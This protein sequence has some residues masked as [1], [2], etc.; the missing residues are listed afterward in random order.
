[1]PDNIVPAQAALDGASGFDSTFN[2]AYH[3]KFDQQSSVVSDIAGGAVAAVVDFGASVWNSLPGTDYVGT[4]QMLSRVSDNAM[5]VYEE[6][7]DAVHATSFIAG[8]FAPTG[9]ALKGMS[10]LRAGAKGASW[11]SNA[12]KAADLAK[13]DKLFIEGAAA[14]S[15]YRAA[16]TAFYAR[17]LVNQVTDAAAMEFA[18][19]GS[20]HAHPLMEDYMADPVKNFGISLAFGGVIGGT[21]GHIA[22]RFQVGKLEHAAESKIVNELT[23]DLTVVHPAEQFAEQIASHQANIGTLEKIIQGKAALGK[24][25]ANDLA[26]GTANK[27]L[28]ST[29]AKQNEAFEAMVSP[30]I[31][32]ATKADPSIR[33]AM[34]EMV[35][36][37]G[38]TGAN[39]VGYLTQHVDGA[40][41]ILKM[42]AGDSFLSG[43]VFGKKVSNMTD[44]ITGIKTVKES[45]ID[46]AYSPEFGRFYA[47]RDVKHYGRARDLNISVDA[48]AKGMGDFHVPN[49][50]IAEETL[51]KNSAA[52]DGH[53]I[54]ALKRVDEMSAKQVKEIVMST[55]DLPLRNAVLA[56]IAKEPDEF[57]GHKWKVTDNRPNFEAFNQQ[58]IVSQAANG[59]KPSHLADNMLFTTPEAM[60]RY[61]LN[62]RLAR[63]TPERGLI[64]SWI[65]GDKEPLAAAME[66][67]RLGKETAGDAVGTAIY[68]SPESV[69]LR[70]K[71]AANADKDGYVYLYRGMTKGKAVGH[72]RLDSYTTDPAKAL[73]FT[74][75]N[76]SNVRLYKVNVDDIIGGVRD[77]PG[78]QGGVWKNEIIVRAGTLETHA[79]PATLPMT[80]ATQVK[81]LAAKTS[82]GVIETD[83]MQLSQQLID[84]KDSTISSM[85]AQGI[86]LETIAIRTNTPLETVNIFSHMPEGSS[87]VDIQNA[88]GHMEY[89]SASR[90]GQYLDPTK[91]TLRVSSDI[92][93]QNFSQLTANLD[94][95]AKFNMHNEITSAILAGSGSVFAKDLGSYYFSKERQPLL[96]MIRAKLGEFVNGGSGNRFL[97]SSDHFSRNMGDVGMIVNTMGKDIVKKTNNAIDSVLEPLNLHYSRIMKDS[98]ALAEY[99]TAVNVNAGIKGWREFKDGQFWIRR[100][101][102]N[103]DGSV[104]TSLEAVTFQGKE[105]KV[106]SES[107]HDIFTQHQVAGRELYEMK[108]TIN[109]ILGKPKMSD[110]GLWLPSFNPK[111]KFIAYVHNKVDDTTRLLWGNTPEELVS[112]K[113]AFEASV[114]PARLGK[115]INVVMKS[116]QAIWNTLNGRLDPMTMEIAN[117]Q[118]QH[119]GSSAGAVVKANSDLLGEI[120]GGYEHYIGS[121]MRQIAEVSMHDIMDGLTRMSQYNMRLTEGQALSPVAKMLY[122]PKDTANVIKN[123]ML[124]NTNLNEYSSWRQVNQSFETGLSMTMTKVGQIFNEAVKPFIPTGIFRRKAEL[125]GNILGKVDYET[126]SRKMEAVGAV[127]PWKNFDDEAAKI[128]GLAKLTDHKD[129][130]KRVIYASNALA[131]TIALR[132]G[133]LAQPIVNAMSLPILT[134]LA[135][136]DKMPATFMGIQKATAKVGGVQVMYEGARAMHDPRF[137]SLRT[138]W[139]ELGYFDPHIS[140]ANNTLKLARTFDR[141]AITSIENALDSHLVK[142]L[143]KPADWS[144]GL[145]RAQTMHTGAVL[146]KRLYPEL[147]DAGVTIFARDFMDRA[148]GNYHSAQRPVFFQGTMGV[149]L[150][151]FQTYMLTL[152]QSIYRHLELKNYAALGKGALAQV[153]I[154]GGASMPGFNQISETIGDHFSNNNVDLTTGTYRA[155]GDKTADAILYGLPSSMGPAFYT[156]GEIA[157]RVPNPVGGLQNMVGVNFVMQAGDMI[158]HVAESVKAENPDMARTLA[159][160]LSMQS[161]SRPLARMSE[162]ASGY[163]VTRKGNSVAVPE[164]VWTPVGVISRVLSTRPL[165]EAKVRQAM[166]LNTMYGAA[167]HDARQDVQIKLKTAIRG[168]NLSDELLS[169]LMLQYMH[170]GGTPQG[171]R[172]AVNTAIGQSNMTGREQLAHRLRPD[173][174]I[175]YM[176]DNL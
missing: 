104:G 150:G 70:T 128:F 149:A 110:I 27:Y 81:H 8:M 33:A 109:G 117:I 13:I 41:N 61:N 17:G 144:E 94:G 98:V 82:T 132:V 90:I 48:L 76:A 165:E 44:E 143:S 118:M 160:A 80:G 50:N 12:G 142:I 39:E 159:E 58:I 42:P 14:T 93:K 4:E 43:L 100:A 174:A 146:A 75:G 60:E 2:S 145:V 62:S 30:E 83:A 35:V 45:L 133:E 169:K 36:N 124:G 162:I 64:G 24:V 74:R 57:A 56:R 89:N 136:A 92:H 172:S 78:K 166:H 140:E 147:D 46:V 108:N 171:W 173:N 105:Y 85:L 6:H 153:G 68:N 113:H 86:P 40:G 120:A 129:T 11:F 72:G 135:I 9:L 102:K 34:L 155:V 103:E 52:I 139:K 123:T 156:R 152:G 127:N 49:M 54:A 119:S 65:G 126:L 55:D 97:T 21:V 79:T 66:K 77:I 125:D 10:A 168:D 164:D 154:F 116:D 19:L 106:V 3:E 138:L 99:N 18:L 67:M 31:L 47:L 51:S 176:V 37:K 88:V 95:N 53:Y 84:G 26:V 175:N 32:A 38:F 5:R 158:K 148:V 87:V 161:M 107:V 151:L 112:A 20:M 111:N 7:P 91:K 115:E 137:E 29:K 122:A 101:T 96:G 16:K 170:K 163:S 134:S 63:G 69:A 15:E 114:D 141:G 23:K 157:P 22:D 59:V 167:D 73:E 28:L 71:F 25:E 1:M 131:A 121:H 130:S